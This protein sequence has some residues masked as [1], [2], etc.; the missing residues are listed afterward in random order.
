[1]ENSD[2]LEL[3]PMGGEK[4]DMFSV[5]GGT[6]AVRQIVPQSAGIRARLDF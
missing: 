4:D 3:V 6:A 2:D 1:M 5:A